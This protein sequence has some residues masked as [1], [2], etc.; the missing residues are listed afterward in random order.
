MPMPHAHA[1][2]LV[3]SPVLSSPVLP[4]PDHSHSQD[5]LL[6]GSPHGIAPSLHPLQTPCVPPHHSPT[7]SHLPHLQARG[8]H[9]PP[10]C[11]MPFHPGSIPP[12]RPTYPT[13][14]H[15]L[16]FNG[17][18]SLPGASS[19]AYERVPFQPEPAG[20]HPL[21]MGMVYGSPVSAP[22]S[23]A[24]PSSPSH[25][26][27][28]L[29]SLGYHCATPA[30][31]TSPTHALSQPGMQLPRALSYH[32]VGQRSASCPTP[33]NVPARMVPL[34]HS[35]PSSPQLHSLPYQSPTSSSP[36]NSPLGAQP[37]PQ[38]SS[39]VMSGIPTPG[40]MVHPLAPQ[41]G[42][43]TSE[44][45]RLNIKQEPVDREL[46]FRSVGLQG[47]TLD[48]GECLCF[49]TLPSSDFLLVHRCQSPG[50]S[51]IKVSVESQFMH[52][53]LLLNLNEYKHRELLH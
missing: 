6:S 47:I 4:S 32:P 37:S 19:Q 24:S 33:S 31:V 22:A 34:P 48:D 51:L 3:R 11:Q 39:P 21:G 38:A 40:P 30:Q 42:P 29:H 2:G 45:E 50:T 5:G 16:P 36:A 53:V 17:Q 12:S 10:E 43:F 52:L 25:S 23:A 1:V 28:Q 14:Q 27:P 9:H 8:L 18:A 20:C 49:Y 35:G 15:N 44:G 7:F 46:T 41:Q 26:S 13:L